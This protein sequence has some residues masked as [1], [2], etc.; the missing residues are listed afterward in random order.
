MSRQ[1]ARPLKVGLCLPITEG[2]A[3]SGTA[4]WNDVKAMAWHAE[5]VG[6]ETGLGVRVQFPRIVA[7]IGFH[8]LVRMNAGY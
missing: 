1:A 5:A 6:F 3:G 4:R 8:L 7:P 2:W